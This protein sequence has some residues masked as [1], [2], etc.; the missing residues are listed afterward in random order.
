MV[1]M[2]GWVKCR[3][4]LSFT[5]E[6]LQTLPVVCHFLGQEFERHDAVQPRVLRLVDDAHPAATDFF[7]DAVMRDGLTNEC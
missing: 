3:C 5:A 6:A 7:E 2:F 1:Q 4:G